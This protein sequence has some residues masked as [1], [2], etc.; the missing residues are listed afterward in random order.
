M[1]LTDISFHVPMAPTCRF[2]AA[3]VPRTERRLGVLPHEY[4]PEVDGRETKKNKPLLELADF[5]PS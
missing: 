5:A 3:H 4:V 2:H 1:S